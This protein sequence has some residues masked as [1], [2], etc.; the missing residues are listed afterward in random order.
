MTSIPYKRINN[1]NWYKTHYNHCFHV[2]HDNINSIKIDSILAG[3]RHYNN[4]WKILFGNGFI[5]LGICRDRVGIAS[6]L[7][8]VRDVAFPPLL[9]NVVRLS[10]TNNINKDPLS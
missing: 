9:K 5:N 8:R 4:V 10:A 7:W 3:I 6:V 1:N 2:N